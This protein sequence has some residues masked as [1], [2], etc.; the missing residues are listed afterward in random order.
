METYTVT[1]ISSEA[2][3]SENKGS[4]DRDHFLD[5]LKCSNPIYIGHEQKDIT[6][7]Q[8]KAM[9]TYKRQQIDEPIHFLFTGKKKLYNEK[10]SGG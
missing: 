10:M 3:S 5:F 8:T 9:P 4:D 6:E 2:V 7:A 1:E